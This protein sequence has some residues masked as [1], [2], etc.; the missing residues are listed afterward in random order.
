MA[1]MDGPGQA[2]N[3]LNH[4]VDC[5]RDHG[6]CGSIAPDRALT[7]PRPDLGVGC[8]EFGDFFVAPA[9]PLM[10]LASTQCNK[11]S[12]P[13]AVGIRQVYGGRR[14]LE[15]D[16]IDEKSNTSYEENM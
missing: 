12:Q 16:D 7:Q 1:K 11:A 10:E 2:E 4:E 9:Q 13:R 14:R 3:R 6:A 8:F 15:S 5:Q